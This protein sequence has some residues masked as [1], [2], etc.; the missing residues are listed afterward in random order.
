MSTR[1]QLFELL[2]SIRDHDPTPRIMMV[3][4]YLDSLPPAKVPAAERRMLALAIAY[5]ASVEGGLKGAL[6]EFFAAVDEAER[7]LLN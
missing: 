6:D 3:S 2:Q 5:K 7:K 4:A 1:R